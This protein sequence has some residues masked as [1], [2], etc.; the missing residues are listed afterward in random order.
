MQRFIDI[1]ACLFHPP[2]W[3]PGADELHLRPNERIDHSSG[4]IEEYGNIGDKMMGYRVKQ[5]KSMSDY[6]YDVPP[7]PDDPEAPE[8]MS[9]DA[10]PGIVREHRNPRELFKKKTT[11]NGLQTKT[12]PAIS[13]PY[14]TIN[15]I[16]P[17][18]AEFT[19]IYFHANSEDLMSSIRLGRL[20][21]DFMRAT[22]IIP[23]Y[24]GYSLLKA[25]S[26]DMDCIR[27]DM[28]FFI[29]ELSKKGVINIS[30]T[31]LFVGWPLIQGRSLGSHLTSYLSSRFEFHSAVIFCGFQS[32]AK[33]VES[34]AGSFF[35]KI[36]KQKCDNQEYLKETKTP[37]LIIH[38][39][40]VRNWDNLLGRADTLQRHG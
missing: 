5:V 18:E 8:G 9:K 38:G 27:T 2:G 26:P 14:V 7:L 4:D 10:S 32:V 37:V 12:G 16:R 6:Y 11:T 28:R 3:N 25:Y 33:I 15:K 35:G 39:Q 24:R 29:K 19:V 13:I 17:E 30:K 1:T 31:I 40:K 34:K 21:S 20:L 22:V 23:E 36:V